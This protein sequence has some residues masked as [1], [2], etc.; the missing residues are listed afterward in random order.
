VDKRRTVA[1]LQAT[2]EI[3]GSDVSLL[4][5]VER[6][7]KTRFRPLVLL[8]SDG[9]L[10]GALREQGCEVIIIKEMLKL[11]TRKGLAYLLRYC[12]NYPRAV[13]TILQQIRRRGVVLV[14]TNTLHN[15]YGC[16]AALLAGV[17]H[18]WHVREIVMQSR[19]VRRVELLLA[20]YAADRVIAT[21]VA[22]A[23][24]FAT[25][26]Q[27]PPGNLV[28]IP[29]GIDLNRFHP[30]IDGSDI[31]G[32]LGIAPDAP[33]VG[34]VARLD[35]WKGVDVFLHAAARCHR[36]APDIQFLIV[37]GPIDG[38][39]PYAEK[40]QQL[41]QTLRLNGTVH[42]SH[43]RYRPEDMPR[44][45][46]AL[47]LLVLASTWPEPFGL[48]ILEAMATGK[49]VIATDHGGPRE[50][51]VDGETAA[52]V[53]PGDA[54][55]LADAI[56]G[57]VRDPQRALQMGLAGRRRAEQLFD[58]NQSVQK[59]E[60]LYDELITA[61]GSHRGEDPGEPR[62]VSP[63]MIGATNVGPGHPAGSAS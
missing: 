38:Q 57:M 16:L 33:L 25:N 63:R 53:P 43:W 26:G 52:L 6:L 45:H 10:V 8:P 20:K 4:R 5:I 11:T 9:Q 62:G 39:E 37:G 19:A 31:R 61:R 46:A 42:F 14:H 13:R 59:L 35:H 29:N 55:R 22:V 23:D 56:L 12:L 7:D 36:I 50:I 60:Q 27:R 40:M 3:G 34:L 2:S 24:M 30:S 1:Y 15:L 54:S 47:N 51:C 48:V 18:V 49:P 44:V 58:T 17:P 28:K 41:A 32:E 21:S